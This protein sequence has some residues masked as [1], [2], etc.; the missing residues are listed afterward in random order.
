MFKTTSTIDGSTIIGVT[1]ATV[2]FLSLVIISL[3]VELLKISLNF[4]LMAIFT[5]PYSGGS[6]LSPPYT[7]ISAI[8]E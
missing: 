6:S 2:Y 7:I 5:R 4:G 1:E 3:L 8:A